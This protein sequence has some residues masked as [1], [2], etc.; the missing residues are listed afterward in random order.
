MNVLVLV[1]APVGL[2]GHVTRWMIEVQAGVFVGSPSKRI[3]DR[4]WAL[5][6]DRIGDGH[7]VLIE[8]STAEQ[9]WS[10]RTAGRERWSPID[11]DGLTLMS[12]PR[13]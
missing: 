10:I 9:G 12:R 5:I 1:D 8:A 6:A 13:R 4:L 11:F 7:A 2:R 3:R